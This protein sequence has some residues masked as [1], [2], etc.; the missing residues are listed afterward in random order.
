MNDQKGILSSGLGRVM[1]NK[2]YIFWFWLL[3]IAFFM[4]GLTAT[5]LVSRQVPLLQEAGWTREQAVNLQTL[6]GFGLLFAR[7]A[8]GF[9]IDYIFAPRV[10][11][12]VSIGGASRRW[13]ARCPHTERRDSIRQ[14]S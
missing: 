2:R 1:R 12:A 8:V 14:R 7:V 10:M 4:L 13:R 11:T 3:N 6:F 9:I 5:S